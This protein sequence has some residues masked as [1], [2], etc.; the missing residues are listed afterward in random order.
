MVPPVQLVQVCQL[1]PEP[2]LEAS[3]RQVQRSGEGADEGGEVAA[4]RLLLAHEGEQVMGQGLGRG[5]RAHL[6]V[7]PGPVLPSLDR[8]ASAE[9]REARVHHQGAEGRVDALGREGHGCLR[10]RDPDETPLPES[11]VGAHG[12]RERGGERT[13]RPGDR[14]AAAPPGCKARSW[15][16]RRVLIGVAAMLRVPVRYATPPCAR[17][18]PTAIQLVMARSRARSGRTAM[19]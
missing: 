3:L 4:D 2:L 1:A 16:R 14:H 15:R 12:L 5:A 18:A 7:E 6:G 19:R 13:G 10:A 17:R 11:G 9:A 8:R